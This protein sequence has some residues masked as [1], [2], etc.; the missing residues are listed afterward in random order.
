MAE[1][2]L[3]VVVTSPVGGNI[4]GEGEWVDLRSLEQFYRILRAFV[5]P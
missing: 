1:A 4:H 5:V 3:P 2:G